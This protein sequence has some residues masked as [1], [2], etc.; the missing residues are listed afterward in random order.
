MV[1]KQKGF[2]NPSPIF[3]VMAKISAKNLAKATTS[4]RVNIVFFII[5]ILCIALLA[6]LAILQKQI[7]FFIL[8]AQEFGLIGIFLASLVANASIFLVI[9]IDVVV[10]FAAKL[11][12]PFTLSLS[13]SFG[14][15]LGE[16]TSYLVGYA[17]ISS[18][19]EDEE[20][21][22]EA[23]KKLLDLGM[24]FIVLG[25][26]TPFPFDLIG[27]AAGMLRYNWMK[28]LFAAWLGKFIRY[29]CISYAATYGLE[30]LSALFLR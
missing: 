28:F 23:E 3:I 16:M 5:F 6:L 20:K 22:K 9:P 27:L 2:I 7:K 18:F 21:L 12:N 26:L 19:K 15:A 10:F 8:S 13:A 30:F 25:S 29:L 24:V 14:A 4:R 11:L 17:G 1:L